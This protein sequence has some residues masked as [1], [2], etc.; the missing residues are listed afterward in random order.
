MKRNV[1]VLL[2][3][4]A[5]AI[6]VTGTVVYSQISN[7]HTQ[8][9][10]ASPS[11]EPLQ[12]RPSSTATTSPTPFS[13]A[14]PKASSAS[15]STEPLPIDPLT[16]SNLPLT[17]TVFDL[18]VPD[19]YS[20]I[21]EAVDHA[22]EGAA[23]LVRTGVYN[24]SV[25]VNKPVWLVGED[26]QTTIIDAHSVAPDLCILVDN[27][28]VTGFC[29]V[30][31]AIPAQGNWMFYWD[32]VP[33]KQLQ[34]I[35]ISGAS[36]C[37]IYHN[38]LQNSSVGV[39]LADSKGNC[40]FENEFL[41]NGEAVYISGGSHFVANNLIANRNGG[42]TGL[43]VASNN[44]TIINNT[45]TEGTG[46][47]WFKSGENNTLKGNKLQG[48]FISLLMG[49]T[50]PWL[51]Y[52]NYVDSS[53]TVNGKPV[54]YWIDKTNKTVPSDA[55]AVILVNSTGMIIKDCVLPQSTYGITLVNT[56]QSTVE[57]NQL[58]AL[59]PAQLEQYHTPGVP[60]YILLLNSSGN[61][62][63]SNRAA[64][65][66]NSSLTNMLMHN[67]G[68]IRLSGSDNNQITQNNVTKIG[69]TAID[70]SGIV[71]SKS[72]NNTISENDIWGNSAGVGVNGGATFN[73]IS[74]NDI[75]GNAQ[76]GIVLG[77]MGSG[78]KNNL[79]YGNNITD[80]DNEGILDSA[81]GTQIIGNNIPKNSG[82]GIELSNSVNCTIKGNVIEG[83]FF[84][85]FHN[86]AINCTVVANNVSLNTRYGQ[87]GIWFQSDVA[88]TFYHNNFI[89]AISFDHS[90]Y[91]ANVWDNGKEGNWWYFYTGTDADGD[92]IGDTPYEIGPNNI[93][94]YP[95]IKPFDI[96]K[97]IPQT[98][99]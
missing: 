65:W 51:D 98:P 69:F 81:F 39:D 75:Y 13:L 15:P 2:S 5:L 77:T 49:S 92:G 3:L 42:G 1:V 74:D 20:C 27:V 62:L 38:I 7:N 6:L 9:P 44:N 82:N 53:N 60:L 52:D 73:R 30:N 37:H 18:V 8:P 68:V 11:T 76:G 94:R 47:V 59:D 34:N 56:N 93:D 96:T 70:W 35:Q 55:G 50:E 19:D 95:L 90:N 22:V 85:M 66:L 79:I 17:P 29:M 83:F 54:Y 23:I 71:L 26:N 97:A 87:Y 80:N 57:N 10:A 48:N 4:V 25:T 63:N 67:T 32:Y 86:S 46:G 36:G 88:G 24:E 45:I 33:A 84:G 89:S 61:Q 12:P 28:N 58:A 72:S 43:V 14:P 21:Q 41:G 16:T 91:T 99:P 64:L 31:T 78:T 40:V